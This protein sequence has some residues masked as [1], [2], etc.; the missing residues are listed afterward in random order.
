MSSTPVRETLPAAF[1]IH[2]GLWEEMD[3]GRFWHR[4]G[5][6]SG[7]TDAG[8]EVTAPDRPLHPESWAEEA[9]QLTAV[10][11]EP[12]AVII[13][14]S[15]GCSAAVRIAIDAPDRVQRLILA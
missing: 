13:A 9:R 5:I 14:G 7:L 15:N 2:G 1:L 4:P 10:L 11:P 8:I 3:G 6:R 12:P